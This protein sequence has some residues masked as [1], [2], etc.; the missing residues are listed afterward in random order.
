[1]KENHLMSVHLKHGELK[2]GSRD[3]FGS[4]S[5][6]F[7]VGNKY[8]MDKKMTAARLDLYLGLTCTQDYLSYLSSAENIETP[9]KTKRGKGGG[10][11]AHLY[12]LIDAAM[13]LSPELKTEIIKIFVNQRL[14]QIRNDSSDNFIELNAQLV[15]SAQDVFGK[16]AHNG[17]FINLSKIIKNRVLNDGQQWN[18]VTSDLLNERARIEQALTAILRL[19]LV[20]DWEHLKELAEKI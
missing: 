17:H 9:I 16:E 2:I 11:W 5:D 7:V 10:T 14:L 12:V 19:G 18:N 15:L 1:M 13:Y 6:L 20:R 8:R 4:L 3:L